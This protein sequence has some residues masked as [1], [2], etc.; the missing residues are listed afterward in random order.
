MVLYL[1]VLDYKLNHD[2]LL[3]LSKKYFTITF[4]KIRGFSTVHKLRHKFNTLSI[5]RILYNFMTVNET[6]FTW[7]NLFFTLVFVIRI[8]QL[9]KYIHTN[10]KF[11]VPSS[12]LIFINKNT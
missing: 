11:F 5:M 2:K 9:W 7:E 1:R 12:E 4:F 6:F 8:W 10:L 3:N